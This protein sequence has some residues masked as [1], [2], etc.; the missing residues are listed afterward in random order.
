MFFQFDIFAIY[1][2]IVLY[3][4]EVQIMVIIIYL[5]L[6]FI[7]LLMTNF[8]IIIV[9]LGVAVLIGL[10]NGIQDFKAKQYLADRY[11]EEKRNRKR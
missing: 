6:W 1:Y 3:E 10:V 5:V 7:L 9:G 4:R 8:N 11:D 2:T